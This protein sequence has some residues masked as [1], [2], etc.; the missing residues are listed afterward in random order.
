[1]RTR[2]TSRTPRTSRPFGTHRARRALRRRVGLFVAAKL[3][4]AGLARPNRFRFAEP[5][6]EPRDRAVL[7][8]RVNDARILGIDARLK[9]VAP[10]ADVQVA[11]ARAP[12]I[13]GT[14][15]SAHRPVVLRAA[16]HVIERLR[17]VDRHTI[18]LG[19]REAGEEPPA[20]ALVV[21]LVKTAVVA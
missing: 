18:E 2:R 9:P 20:L 3:L 17:V 15:G 6:V 5:Q 16:A 8:A 10:A 11:R 12:D 13:D 19:H 1:F 14:R 21:G 7:R 4:L